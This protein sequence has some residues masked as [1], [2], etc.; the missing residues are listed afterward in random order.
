M[1]KGLYHYGQQCEG[2]RTEH[3][4]EPSNCAAA[5]LHA[6]ALLD[7]VAKVVLVNCIHNLGYN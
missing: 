3:E 5:C 6:S 4:R 2:I 1:G 7:K